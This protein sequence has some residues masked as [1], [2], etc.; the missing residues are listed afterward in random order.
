[1]TTDTIVVVPAPEPGWGTAFDLHGHN[2]NPAY[3]GFVWDAAKSA[4]REIAVLATSFR[5]VADR[6]RLVTEVVREDLGA[7]DSATFK[8][9]DVW[10]TISQFQGNDRDGT[11]VAINDDALVDDDEALDRLVKALGVSPDIIGS[12]LDGHDTAFVD[13]EPSALDRFAGRV[14]RTLVAAGLPIVPNRT[15]ARTLAGARIELDHDDGPDG[16]VSV[17]WQAHPRLRTEPPSGDCLLAQQ[18]MAD[19]MAT[20]LT[21]AGFTTVARSGRLLLGRALEVV[22]GHGDEPRGWTVLGH[23][24]GPARE[25]DPR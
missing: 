9:G 6:F 19:A 1:M 18:A 22:G 4:Y 13:T 5:A 10:Y 16:S 23:Q 17:S 21:S 15:S 12:R 8:L 7:V 25:G 24:V 14:R 3:Q 20:I 11:E 2:G